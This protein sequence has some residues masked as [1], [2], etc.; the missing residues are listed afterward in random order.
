MKLTT[1]LFVLFATLSVNAKSLNCGGTEPFWDAKINLENG[2]VKISDPSNA[3]GSTI[4]TKISP[5]AGTSV[6][7][8]FVAKG[9]YTSLAVVSNE[10]CNDGMSDEK[11]SYSVIMTGYSAEPLVGCCK[12]TEPACFDPR[13]AFIKCEDGKK[14][15]G[16]DKGQCE[17]GLVAGAICK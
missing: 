9:K 13:L 12:A 15:E 2:L 7:Y 4:K 6:E 1:I 14:F 17:N 3:K 11:Y 5:A 16:W 10:S 8:A